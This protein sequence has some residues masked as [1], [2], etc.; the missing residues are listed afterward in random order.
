V[1]GARPIIRIPEWYR[2]HT[3]SARRYLDS[4]RRWLGSA[5]W[6]LVTGEGDWGRVGLEAPRRCQGLWGDLEKERLSRLT[7]LTHNPLDCF[8]CAF[9][10]PCLK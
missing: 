1:C 9:A 5:F 8:A 3:L 4:D 6:G 7:H 2:R 10:G